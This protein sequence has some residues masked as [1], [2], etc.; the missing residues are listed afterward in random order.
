MIKNIFKGVVAL[1]FIAVAV[2]CGSGGAKAST[3]TQEC[4]A[5]EPCPICETCPELNPGQEVYG[6]FEDADQ[7]FINRL[8]TEDIQ[9]VH[10]IDGEVFEENLAEVGL[11]GNGT[12][13]TKNNINLPDY[14]GTPIKHVI[15]IKFTQI[16]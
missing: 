16:R 14:K 1:C 5:P 9:F 15:T 2:G 12:E 10:T 3:Q 7:N 8:D 6:G 4:P 13:V 11:D